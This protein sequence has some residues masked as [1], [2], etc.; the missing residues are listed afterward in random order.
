MWKI[1]EEVIALDQERDD[2]GLN[3]AMTAQIR[4][5]RMEVEIR[6]IVE[7]SPGLNQTTE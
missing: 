2:Q 6:T 1:Y 4:R 3:I 7:E 5:K